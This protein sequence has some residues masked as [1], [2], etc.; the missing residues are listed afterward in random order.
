MSPTG[1]K[2]CIVTPR[3]LTEL[4]MLKEIFLTPITHPSPHRS[5]RSETREVEIVPRAQVAARKIEV[6]VVCQAF[7]DT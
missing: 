7:S 3:G 5:A 6:L 1:L 2:L 4:R